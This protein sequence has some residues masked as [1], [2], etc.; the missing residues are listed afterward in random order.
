MTP[1]SEELKP[2]LQPDLQPAAP[3]GETQAHG[4]VARDGRFQPGNTLSLR[5]GGRSARVA[6]G[7][8][9]E[10]AEAAAALAARVAAIVADL[11][12]AD[13]TSALKLG[14][15]KDHAQLEVVAAYLWNRLQESGPL[16]AKG[17]TKAALT[18]W[19]LPLVRN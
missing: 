13:D 11:G 4:P 18:A 3:K 7:L 9:P 12:G 1:E 14:R 6:A 19:L 8:M 10:Q 2:G 5:H 16:T 15:V 17:R